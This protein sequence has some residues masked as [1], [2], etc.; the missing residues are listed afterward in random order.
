V[1]EGETLYEIASFYQVNVYDIARANDI[2]N[3]NFI[4]SGLS[5]TIPAEPTPPISTHPETKQIIVVLSTQRVYAFDKSILQ[6]TFIVS[7]GTANTPTVE[8]EFTIYLKYEADRMTGPGYDLDD[9]PWTMYF[10]EGYALHGTYWHSNFGLPMS[11][12]CVNLETQ[13]AQW[14]YDFAPLGT[15][16]LVIP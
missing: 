8:G 15:W 2:E 1:K 13:D 11:H 16:V 12:G 3:I 6:N 9:V 4:Y 10:F 5:L 7:T 14:L